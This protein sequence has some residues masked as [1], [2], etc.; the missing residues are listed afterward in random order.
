MS[1]HPVKTNAIDTTATI[2]RHRLGATRCGRRLG[3]PSTDPGGGEAL[4]RMPTVCF[5]G[6][7]L[8]RLL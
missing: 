4:V 6:S 1:S 5:N 8:P 3:G 2:F 7:A